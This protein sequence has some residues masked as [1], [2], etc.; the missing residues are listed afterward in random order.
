MKGE[1]ERGDEWEREMEGRWIRE[2]GER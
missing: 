1:G 2:E